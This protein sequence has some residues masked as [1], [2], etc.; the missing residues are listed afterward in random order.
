MHAAFGTDRFIVAWQLDGD[1]P[2]ETGLD[3][4]DTPLIDGTLPDELPDD[5][6]VRIAIPNDIFAVLDADAAK[7]TQWRET[8]RQAFITYLDRGY[9]VAG[10][11][12]GEGAESGAYMLIK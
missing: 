11:R 6:R 2:R 12:R 5:A 4:S 1:A 10:F 8:T 3:W 7:A 9:S